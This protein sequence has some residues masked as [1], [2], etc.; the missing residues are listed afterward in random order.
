[1]VSNND[2]QCIDW[3][4]SQSV[5]QSSF[6]HDDIQKTSDGLIKN[7]TVPG[8]MVTWDYETTTQV[9]ADLLNSINFIE[10]DDKTREKIVHKFTDFSCSTNSVNVRL[11]R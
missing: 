4:R 11:A 5:N 3:R 10:F 8:P 1:M 6:S 7:C 2:Q 9:R